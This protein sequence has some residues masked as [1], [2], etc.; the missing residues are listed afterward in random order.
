M[1]ISRKL[2]S[3]V[4]VVLLAG[5]TLS[6]CG[7]KDKDDA[8]TK[9]TSS[10]S[11]SDKELTA[12]TFFTTL[13]DEQQKAGSA[14]MVMTVGIGGQSIKADGDVKIGKTFADTSMSMDMDMGSAGPATMRMLLVDKIFYMN[15]GQMTKGKYAKVDLTDEDNAFTKQFSQLLDQMDPT[16]QLEQ[17]QKAVTS[18]EKKGKPEQIDG[19]EAQPYELVLDTTKIDAFADLPAGATVPKTITYE[20]YMGS[21]NLLRRMTCDVSGAKTQLD[22]SKWGEDV[23]IKAPP[24]SEVTDQD[25]SKLMG[26]AASSS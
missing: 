14:H 8:G 26:G 13:I 16:K 24:A 5:L 25:L 1:T 15:L 6:A 19:V 18:F 21:D 22:Y 12:D 17:F 11:A 10:S 2:S 9:T 4:A 20:M 3:L 23:D 7:D